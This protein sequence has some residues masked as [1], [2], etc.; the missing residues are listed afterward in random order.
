V[1]F[2]SHASVVNTTV[3]TQKGGLIQAARVW[4]TNLT[5]QTDK[6]KLKEKTLGKGFLG[7][8]IVYGQSWRFAFGLVPKPKALQLS[9]PTNHPRYHDCIQPDLQVDLHKAVGRTNK[10]IPPRAL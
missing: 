4:P 1:T 8:S 2:S 7:F 3:T 10:N 9:A 6:T 5:S